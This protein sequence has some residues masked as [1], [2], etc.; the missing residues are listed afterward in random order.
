[1]AEIRVERKKG[2]PVW[3]IL[4]ALLALAALAWYFL[5]RDDQSEAAP[6][7]A[8]VVELDVRTDVRPLSGHLSTPAP[9]GRL[10][11]ILNS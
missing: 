7:V 8:A 9:A 11:A 3:V 10:S 4:L 2:I 6:D 1:M 5:G